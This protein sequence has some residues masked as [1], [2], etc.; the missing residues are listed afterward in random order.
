MGQIAQP[1]RRRSS[2]VSN[3]AG[4]QQSLNRREIFES[5]GHNHYT[6]CDNQCLIH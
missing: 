5:G 6:K 1:M 4:P 3:E 2:L